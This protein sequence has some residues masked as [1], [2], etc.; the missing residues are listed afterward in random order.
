MVPNQFPD[1]RSHVRFEIVGDLWAT[2]TA[3][4]SMPVVNLGEGGALLE[5]AD[6]LLIG[7]VQHLR[8]R[9]GTDS[10]DVAGNVKHVRRSPISPD[11]YLVGIAFTEPSAVARQAI[12][13]ALRDHG[14]AV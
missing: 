6:P 10:V 3:M 1:R 12:E 4:Q 7:S 8:L 2:V 9:L 13:T 11:R 14:G 5:S